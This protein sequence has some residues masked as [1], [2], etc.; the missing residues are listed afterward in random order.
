MEV[1]SWV[2]GTPSG[3]GGRKGDPSDTAIKETGS[4]RSGAEIQACPLSQ[5]PPA[6]WAQAPASPSPSGPCQPGAGPPAGPSHSPSGQAHPLPAA[7]RPVPCS[8]LAAS[9]KDTPFPPTQKPGDQPLSSAAPLPASDTHH[10]QI[11]PLSLHVTLIWTPQSTQARP[12]GG[13]LYPG[14]L[15][16]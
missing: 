10:S 16:P 2:P 9:G 8:V 5:Q 3:G 6:R 4:P 1:F 7:P 12:P 15:P 14:F 13:P 11:P